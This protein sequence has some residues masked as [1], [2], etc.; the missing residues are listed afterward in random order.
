MV[1]LPSKVKKVVEA[2]LEEEVAL[3]LEVTRQ[4]FSHH[5]K[6]FGWP[7]MIPVRSQEDRKK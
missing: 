2:S 6:S 7:Q 4:I 5:L 1:N 3:A